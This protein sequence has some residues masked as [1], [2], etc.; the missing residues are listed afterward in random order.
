MEGESTRMMIAKAATIRVAS[1]AINSSQLFVSLRGL[2]G[3]DG[4]P[5]FPIIH[6][7]E[8]NKKIYRH[9]RR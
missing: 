9:S 3:A 2:S 4:L 1:I 7:E 5:F 8:N 6:L